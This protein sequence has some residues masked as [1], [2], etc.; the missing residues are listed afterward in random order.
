RSRLEFCE[1]ELEYRIAVMAEDGEAPHARQRLAHD[2]GNF[3]AQADIQNHAGNVA[4]GPPQA[5]SEALLDRIA[6]GRKDDRN[7]RGFLLERRDVGRAGGKD[8]VR[9]SR[10]D[11]SRKRREPF[12][13]ALSPNYLGRQ[14][15]T[16]DVTEA[17]KRRT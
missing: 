5:R 2:F 14:I 13:T 4:S 7:G 15:A 16:L 6:G 17:L 12:R 8:E 11:P 3:C 1:L 10:H 9:L